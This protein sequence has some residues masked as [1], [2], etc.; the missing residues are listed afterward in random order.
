MQLNLFSQV[1][2]LDRNTNHAEIEKNLVERCLKIQKKHSPGGT[3]WVAQGTYNT[4]NVYDIT[5]DKV[6]ESL[7]H[8]IDTRIRAYCN[9]LKYKDNI[10][11]KKGWFNIYK[12]GDFQEYHQHGMSHLSAIY[13]LRGDK[14]GARIFFKEEMSMFPIPVEEY[15]STNGEFYWIPFIPGQ[16]II[17]ESSLTHSVEKHL[18]S[19]LR[20]SLSYNYCLS[21]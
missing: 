4:Y 5:Q 7:N 15:T 19:T 16:L 20:F 13:C 14:K 9:A 2:Q 3:D 10:Q 18:C 6:F 11:T 12:K 21:P 1:I 17:F 8:W